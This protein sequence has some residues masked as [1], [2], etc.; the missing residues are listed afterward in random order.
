M[1]FRPLSLL[2][3]TSLAAFAAE[4]V[5]EFHGSI[6]RLDPALD[7]LIAPGAKIEVLASGFN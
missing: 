6:E 5:P 7:A 4:P 3:A 2:L 1:L